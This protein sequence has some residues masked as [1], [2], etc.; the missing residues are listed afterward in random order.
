MKRLKSVSTEQYELEV[1]ECDC[2][3]HLGLDFTYMDQI[4]DF[5]INCPCCNRVFDTK[6]LCK[7]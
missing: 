4:D 3:F 2:G 1:F 5:T 6:K 7:D